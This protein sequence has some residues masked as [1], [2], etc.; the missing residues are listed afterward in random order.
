MG[1]V[2]MRASNAS[3]RVLFTPV[4]LGLESPASPCRVRKPL[5]VEHA[6]CLSDKHFEFPTTGTV[7]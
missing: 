2:L 6:L 3:A 1:A 7:E 5:S 4:S